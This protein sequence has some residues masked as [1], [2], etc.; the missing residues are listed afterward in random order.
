MAMV[1]TYQSFK[2]VN[3][4]GALGRMYHNNVCFAKV[5]KNISQRYNNHVKGWFSRAILLLYIFVHL[6]FCRM[7]RFYNMELHGAPQITLF[8]GNFPLLFTLLWTIFWCLMPLLWTNL[9][10][11]RTS[12]V[13]VLQKQ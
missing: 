6:I 10:H 8:R 5:R 4:R 11:F 3:I 9:Y 1:Q 7:G 2:T 13:S 12:K